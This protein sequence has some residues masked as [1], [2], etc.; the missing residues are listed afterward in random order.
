MAGRTVRNVVHTSVGGTSAR[1]TLSNLY[2][3]G[4]LTVTHATLA[5]AAADDSAAA[6]P[7]TLRRLTFGGA[8]TVVVPAGGRAVSDAVTVAVPSDSDVL[9]S[10]YSPPPPARSP[11]TRAPGRPATSPRASP[12]RTSPAPRSPGRARTGAT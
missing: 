8:T 9:V 2:G 3:T 12:P 10:T 4:P 7:D 1:V 6:D 11:T 5:V